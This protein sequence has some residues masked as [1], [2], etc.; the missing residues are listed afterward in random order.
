MIEEYFEAVKALLQ[1]LSLS[2]LPEVEYDYRDRETGFLKGDLVFK[3]G[4][5]LH[6]REFVRVKFDKPLDRYM[7]V[8]Q[9]MR[10][11]GSL[12]FRYDDSNHFPRLPTAPH[13]KHLGAADVIAADAPDLQSVLREIEALIKP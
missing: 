1:S 6:F 13:H 9:Y 5:R 2:T 8:F 4:S 12:I 11:D 10:A 7:Y 3:D